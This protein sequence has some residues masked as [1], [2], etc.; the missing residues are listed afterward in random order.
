MRTYWRDKDTLYL[1]IENDGPSDAYN[2]SVKDLNKD[3]FLF[4]DIA[5]SFPISTI[6]AGDSIQL[7]LL[8]YSDMPEKARLQ[9]IWEDDSKEKH[10]DKVILGIY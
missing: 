3:S 4:Q 2:V 6:D 8:V 10:T 1:V 9:V 5:S 7:E